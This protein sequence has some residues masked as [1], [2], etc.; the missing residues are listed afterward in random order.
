M[1]EALFVS[2]LRESD[3]P[4]STQ[5]RLAVRASL[6]QYGPCGCAGRMAYEYGEHPTE[7]VRR[8]TWAIAILD[9]E[10]AVA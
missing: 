9:P 3:T 5:V 10:F 4:S 8:M 1:A 2:S 6:D 7:A